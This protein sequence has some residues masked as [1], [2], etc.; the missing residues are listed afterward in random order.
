VRRIAVCLLL[1]GI[2]VARVHSQAAPVP[3]SHASAAETA[4]NRYSAAPDPHFA[5]KVVTT[6]PETGA[7]ATLLQRA[8]QPW[9]PFPAPVHERPVP[10][11]APKH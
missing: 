4:L 1:S 5:Y 7:T 2:A 11:A 3:G 9:L 8:S 10:T 6:L